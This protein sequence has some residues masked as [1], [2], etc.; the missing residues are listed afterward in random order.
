M[1][2]EIESFFTTSTKFLNF[3]Y[4]RMIIEKKNKNVKHFRQF[5]IDY[6]T[7]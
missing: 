4:A 1:L 5:T 6:L 7:Q 3:V 2:K